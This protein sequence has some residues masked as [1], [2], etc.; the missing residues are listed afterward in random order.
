[1]PADSG[2]GPGPS[3]GAIVGIVLV[4]VFILIVVAVVAS[5]PMAPNLNS[6][7]GS[8]NVTQV[9]IQSTDDACGLSGDTLPGFSTPG[10][11]LY[12]ILFGARQAPCTISNVSTGTSGFFVLTWSP[13]YVNSTLELI[14][15]SVDCPASYSGALSLSIS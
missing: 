11:S 14:Q 2:P 9:S 6:G 10:G 5:V 8:V 13:S 12:S 4:V 1:M 15:I 7:L 3:V